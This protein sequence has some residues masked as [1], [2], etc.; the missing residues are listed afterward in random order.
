MA[1]EGRQQ[2][3]PLV[4]GGVM[5]M[6]NPRDVIQAIDAATGDLVWEYRRDRPADLGDYMIGSLID[7]NRNIAIHGERIRLPSQVRLGPAEA[8]RFTRPA[9][10]LAR[11]RG[12]PAA[13]PSA[14]RRSAS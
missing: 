3:T 8:L 14:W 4:R 1:S 7:T 5:F 13:P 10:R 2:G 9:P 6:P 12:Y 11:R